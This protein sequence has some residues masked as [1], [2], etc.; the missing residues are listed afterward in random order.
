MVDETEIEKLR[1]QLKELSKDAQ[2]GKVL[3]LCAM[4]ED[5]L[6]AA[7]KAK[8]APLSSDISARIFGGSGPL[9]TISAKIDIAYA[10]GLYSGGTR[11]NLHLVR[12]IRNGFAHTSQRTNF[13][14]ESIV[15][16][17]KQ[18]DPVIPSEHLEIIFY[19]AAIFGIELLLTE[20][21]K[22][23]EAEALAKSLPA[24]SPEKS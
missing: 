11:R 3:I 22:T 20:A 7:I 8:M 10:L 9:Q 2:T 13:E 21:K 4:L 17:C 6:M 12:K 15:A 24:T 18:I 23:Y 19:D 5:V 14:S 1:A 16:L